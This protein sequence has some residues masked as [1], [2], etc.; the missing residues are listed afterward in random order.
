MKRLLIMRHAKSD[1]ADAS[2]PDFDRPLNR[3]G[4]KDVPRVA[5][6]LAGAAAPD[7]VLSS[8][9]QRAQQTAVGLVDSLG[10]LLG[11]PPEL[12]VDGR[13]YLAP[14][15]V[16]ASTAADVFGKATTALVVAHNPGVEDWVAGLTGALLRMP[17][18]AVA[19]IDNEAD[20]WHAATT[21][22]GQ[23]QWLI[24]PRLLKSGEAPATA[25]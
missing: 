9:A 12:V 3:R 10:E 20:D 23:L 13:L 8:A 5:R 7:L 11:A 15:D 18:A 22:R 21:G 6:F 14:P 19:C 17:T 4:Q 25:G 16:L 1:R 24:T 2:L